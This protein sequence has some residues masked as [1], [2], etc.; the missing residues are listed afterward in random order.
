MIKN[1]FS[2][3]FQNSRISS[4]KI[5]NYLNQFYNVRCHDNNIFYNDIWIK[6][7]G[8]FCE[9]ILKKVF[10]SPLHESYSVIHDIFKLCL[11]NKNFNNIIKIH[12]KPVIFNEDNLPKFIDVNLYWSEKTKLETIVNNVFNKIIES[13]GWKGFFDNSS[14]LIKEIDNKLSLD[15]DKVT[16]WPGPDKVFYAMFVTPL[17]SIKVVIIGA[18]P[19]PSPNVA[20]GL[21]FSH[22]KNH[23]GG[24][25]NIQPSLKNIY[26]ELINCKYFVDQNS[27]DLLSWSK[28][29]VFLINTTLTVRERQSRSHFKIWEKFTS[30]LFTYLSEQCDNL[31]II[32]WGSDA[33]SYSSKFDQNK[34]KFLMAGHPS[35]LNT[36]GNFL[37][38]KHFLKANEYLKQWGKKEIDW[39]LI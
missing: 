37:G 13:T 16:I 23:K 14:E 8:H 22:M 20:M 5:Y 10:S 18:D 34:H 7:L 24:Y 17:K 35:P 32:M 19:Y 36:S 25:G 1:N 6:I 29:G 27:G 3:V 2:F 33:Q 39:N 26:K 21:A 30:K 28:R 31:V 12:I 4:T 15:Y 9:N 38:N 11:L